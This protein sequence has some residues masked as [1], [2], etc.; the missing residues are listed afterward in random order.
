MGKHEDNEPLE[1]FTKS[2]KESINEEVNQATNSVEKGRRFLTWALKNVFDATETD[3]TTQILDGKND[4]GIDAISEVEEEDSNYFRIFQAKYGKSH[5]RAEIFKFRHDVEKF[6][7]LQPKEIKEDRLREA[8]IIIRDKKWGHEAIYV[9][10]Q[11][12]DFKNTDDFKVYGFS[13][14]VDKLWYDITDSAR[15]K[16]DEITLED[17]MMYKN[18][19]IGA[20]SLE[21]LAKFVDRT[22]KYIFESN[23]RK[24]LKSKGKVNQAIQK[25]LNFDPQNAF[26]YNNGITL[27]VKRFKKVGK[28]TI[29]LEEPQIVNGAQTSSAINEAYRADREIKGSIQ[30]T[31]I[32][33]DSETQRNNITLYRNSQ[34]AVKGRDLISLERFHDSIRGQLKQRGYYYEQQAGSWIG[35]DKKEKNSYQGNNIFDNYL[36]P[37]YD[38]RII[39]KDAI[40]AMVAGIFEDPTTPYGNVSKYMPGGIEYPVI[41][42]EKELP[43]DFRLLL[44]PYLVK[45]YSKN[46]FNYGETGVSP[47]EKKYARLLFVTAY[48]KILK[49]YI[50]GDGNL[51]LRKDPTRLDR[52]FKDVDTNKKLLEITDKILNGFFDSV[53]YMHRDENGNE[54]MTLHNFFARHVWTDDARRIFM[55]RVNDKKKELQEI[56]ASFKQH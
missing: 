45:Q 22:K 12:E 47:A 14:I 37:K 10:D 28:N 16:S 17:H 51:D 29:E 35:M 38:R 5:D 19:I 21:E 39:A 26:Y 4:H 55:R 54:K 41:F 1:G 56:K 33:E 46:A 20:V 30:I 40:Q 11:E 34:N 42:N 7:S 3:A 53:E 6:L 9:T 24:Y 25:T 27:V 2:I 43:N 15:G 50:I 36:Y 8:R 48:F 32:T 18:T 13:Q 31:I 23:I 44:Y 52:Y 49:S